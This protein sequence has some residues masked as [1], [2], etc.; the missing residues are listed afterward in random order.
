MWGGSECG[1]MKAAVQEDSSDGRQGSAWPRWPGRTL[2]QQY[3]QEVRATWNN[4]A[5]ERKQSDELWGYLEV[6][7]WQARRGDRGQRGECPQTPWFPACFL[8]VWWCQFLK[9]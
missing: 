1:P 9:P 4:S 7:Y 5:V 8:D 3:R 6:A 2:L